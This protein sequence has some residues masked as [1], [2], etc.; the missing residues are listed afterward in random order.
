MQ[1]P[2]PRLI[3]AGGLPRLGRRCHAPA[4]PPQGSFIAEIDVAEVKTAAVELLAAGA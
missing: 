2:L 1:P 3:V 4:L